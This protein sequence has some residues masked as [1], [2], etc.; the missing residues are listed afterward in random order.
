MSNWHNFWQVVL[1]WLQN[2]FENIE[3][4]DD[5]NHKPKKLKRVT[6]TFVKTC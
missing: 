3:D 6:G 4:E 2:Y 5:H 1:E